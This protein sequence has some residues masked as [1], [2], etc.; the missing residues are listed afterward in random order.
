MKNI[1]NGDSLK[2][3]SVWNNFDKILDYPHPSKHEEKLANFIYDFGKGL[4]LET[5]RD[6]IGNILI[7]KEPS[8]PEFAGKATVT[9]QSHIDMVPQ[10]AEGKIFDFKKDT[11]K[12][13]VDGKFVK[14]DGTTLGADNCIGVA[15]IMSLLESKDVDHGPIEGF[16]TIDE[17]AGM[18]GVKNLRPDFLKGKYLLNLDSEEENQLF[19]GCAGGIDTAGV[20]KYKKTSIPQ[21]YTAYKLT[22]SGLKGGHSGGN[23]HE[24]RGNA[25][26]M[27]GRILY[28]A[29][30]VAS[31]SLFDINGGTLRNV[32]P[33]LASAVILVKISDEKAFIDKNNDTAA[34]LK[35]EYQYAA[36]NFT[37][38]Q[39]KENLPSYM[40][41][42][43][44]SNNIISAIHGCFDGVVRMDDN[45]PIVETSSNMG[46]ITTSDTEIKIRLMQRSSVDSSRYLVSS[47]AEAIFRLA[48]ADDVVIDGA[49]TG[50]KPNVNSPLLK[51][52]VEVHKEVLGIDPM[53]TAIHAGLECGLISAVYPDMD[54]ISFGPTILDAHS[55]NERVEIES[56]EK[57]YK[58]VCGILK[59]V[60]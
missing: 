16:F 48:N 46:V 56:V 7:K 36:P 55:I 32:I 10:K 15:I 27:L 13:Y 47:M 52:C 8:S 17:E 19:I 34:A 58:Y 53:V 43:Y 26:K 12:A 25:I 2:P 4:G 30:S 50:W 24:Y 37:F 23:I 38:T 42:Q 41:D 40:L 33:S 57:A 54:M 11:I 49:Y 31:L 3:T 39:T 6:A 21:G 60:K 14:A 44:I 22:I 20:F 29:K 5:H 45:L 9:L 51:T 28:E 18:T 35:K 1:N 59:K